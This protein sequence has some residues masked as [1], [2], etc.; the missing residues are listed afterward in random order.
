MRKL[1]L[2]LML[3]VGLLCA[4][5]SAIF[6]AP[7]LA[8]RPISSALWKASLASLAVANAMD[9]QSSWGKHEL[10]PALSGT[11]GN[12][13]GHGALIKLGLQ[14][15]LMGV[16]FLITRGHPTRK[17]YRVL[18]AVNFGAAGATAAVASHNYT[19]PRQ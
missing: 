6:A 12:F 13:G 1:L 18:A 19:I 17:L 16:E 2:L 4:E 10:N 11:A 8:P 5:D 7:A 14:G 3:P 15:G 9:L